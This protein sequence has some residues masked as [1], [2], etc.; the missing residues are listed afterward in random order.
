MNE[1]LL[2]STSASPTSGRPSVELLFRDI[3]YILNRGEGKK[4]EKEI[5]KG[6]SGVI[7]PAKVNAIF[8]PTGKLC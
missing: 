6:V 2:D 4:R 8:G 7:H 3:K 5:L 1:P